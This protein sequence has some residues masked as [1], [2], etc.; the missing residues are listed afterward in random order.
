MSNLSA[1][2]VE[3]NVPWYL[4]R[5]SSY[6]QILRLTAWTL[7]F[8]TNCRKTDVIKDKEITAKEIIASEL[9]LCRLAQQES[10][11]GVKDPRLQGLDIFEDKR[12]LRTRTIISNRQDNLNFR[13]PIILDPKHLLTEKIIQHV[14]VKFNHAGSNKYRRQA[15]AARAQLT[16]G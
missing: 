5:F 12:L 14:H 7:R 11:K 2:S 6:S 13:Y 9:L 10:F 15:G 3:N 4:R 1:E 8:L 16:D